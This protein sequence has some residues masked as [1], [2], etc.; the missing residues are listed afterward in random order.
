MRGSCQALADMREVAAGRGWRR[1]RRGLNWLGGG[2]LV[3][4]ALVA[5]LL[6]ASFMIDTRAGYWREAGAVGELAL[7]I[8]L[9]PMFIPALRVSGGPHNFGGG[10]SIL[11]AVPVLL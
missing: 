7:L 6:M 2:Y 5:V 11:L 1:F 9:Y 3:Y 4:H 8:V 10:P